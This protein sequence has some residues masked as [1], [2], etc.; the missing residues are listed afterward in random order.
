MESSMEEPQKLK[1]ELPYD[2]AIPLLGIYPKVTKT[3]TQKDICTPEQH[4]LQ[5]ARYGNSP[6][7]HK[8]MNE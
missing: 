3:L 1:I 5:Q 2:P 7:A 8:W 6:S 4:Y